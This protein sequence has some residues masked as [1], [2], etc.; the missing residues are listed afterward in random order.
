ML[1]LLLRRLF[2]KPW[3]WV[4]AATG[5][6]LL[7]RAYYWWFIGPTA[8]NQDEA[9][10]L[11]NAR[12]LVEG[13]RDEWGVRWP[14]VF[15]SFGDA[16]LPG[17]IYLTA[18]FGKLFGFSDW[19]VRFPSFL[20]GCFLPL[21]LY[22]NTRQWTQSPMA[23]LG[24][25]LLLMISPWSWHYGTIGFEANVGLTLFL[26]ATWCVF[27]PS[28]RW[29]WDVG[30]TILF[31]LAA[32]TYNTPWILLPIVGVALVIWHW[33]D[34]VRIGR[35]GTLMLA[36][37]VSVW[38]LTASAT[39]QKGTITIFQD[40]T[41][42]QMY[43][44]YRAQ[45]SGVTQTLV[46]N[47][48]FYFGSHAMT[49]WV[50]SWSWEF[51]VTE[52]GENPWHNIPGVGHVHTALPGLAVIGIMFTIVKLWK[53][54]WKRITVVFWLLLMSLVPAVLTV[55][56][57][58]ATRSLFFFVIL[59]VFAGWGLAYLYDGLCQRFGTRPWW[60]ILRLAFVLFFVWGFAWWWWPAKVRW[61]RMI[62][63][64]WNAGLVNVLSD[65]RVRNASQVSV[66]DPSGNRYPYAVLLEN[67]SLPEFL[68]TVQRSNPDPA[69]LVRV[70]KVG[71]YNF[72]FQKSDAEGQPGVYIEPNG[73]T[74][75]D[76]VEW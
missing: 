51:L 29:Q 66:W 16:K 10:L 4:L 64:K 48:Y 49:R 9:A 63:P 50:N 36:V 54:Q 3:I 8:L 14:I 37:F 15:R 24:A 73:N 33:A 75:W 58:H 52:G 65:E 25:V 39:T 28:A 7:L 2:N 11:M 55:D 43:P 71:K 62:N 72:V 34:W 60:A 13:A 70:E 46:G 56:A 5:S 42:L 41:L 21:L 18:L 27:R 45:F 59:T 12:F 23:A 22:L 61:Q 19:V 20:A 47:K 32:L 57:P 35:I 76:I 31:L 68:S 74:S 53:M 6:F 44:E 1:L 26:A 38:L 30:G 40:P 67:M 69:G 17:Y